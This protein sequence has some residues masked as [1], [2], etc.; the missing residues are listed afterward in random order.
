MEPE[1]PAFDY[2]R[3]EKLYGE[4]GSRRDERAELRALKCSVRNKNKNWPFGR[5]ELHILLGMW[6]D[7]PPEFAV[8][9][10]S[11][12]RL[13]FLNV[14]EW[15]LASRTYLP[16]CQRECVH[17]EIDRSEL[18]IDGGW[19]GDKN[20]TSISFTDGSCE[21]T[22]PEQYW[23]NIREKKYELWKERYNIG[24]ENKI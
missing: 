5:H 18:T 21:L 6:T 10:G 1:P 2:F 22:T 3:S 17:F 16:S 12:E 24:K 11:T 15:Q 20:T 19:W 8:S 14:R 4:Q 23:S 9:F 7:R 13:G